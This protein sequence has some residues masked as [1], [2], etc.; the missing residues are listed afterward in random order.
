LRELATKELGGTKAQGGKFDV[1]EFHDVVL[2][3][4]AVPLDILEENVRA[5][6][7]AKKKA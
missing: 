3:D 4:G 1:R 2:K 5:W 7:E 6:I